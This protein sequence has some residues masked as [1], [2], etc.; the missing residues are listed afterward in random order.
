MLRIGFLQRTDAVPQNPETP[1]ARTQSDAS[2][3]PT[4]VEVQVISNEDVRAWFVVE[5]SGL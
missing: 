3:N 2:R 4:S 5:R 1:R